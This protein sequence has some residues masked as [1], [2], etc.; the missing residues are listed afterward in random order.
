MKINKK[1]MELPLNIVIMLILGLT[2]F[3]IG[4][5][6]FASFSGEGSETIDKLNSQVKNNIASLECQGD[7]WICAPSARIKN[8]DSKNFN[9]F[10]ANKGNSDSLFGINIELS[11]SGD[12]TVISNN[13]GELIIYYPNVEVPI[14]RGQSASFPY[15]VYT[16][17]VHTSPCSFTT[18]IVETKGN[19][20]TPLIIRVE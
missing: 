4:F 16:N 17:R 6:M 19:Y 13:C 3:G 11:D 14:Q 18:I 7:E 12:R 15:T 5:S 1:A 10:V 2:L 20:K 8:G 9:I